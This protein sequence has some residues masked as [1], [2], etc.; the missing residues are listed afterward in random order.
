[1]VITI[2]YEYLP[3][4]VQF[5]LILQAVVVWVQRSIYAR[6][7]KQRTFKWRYWSQLEY[8]G[9]DKNQFS[10]SCSR[11]EGSSLRRFLGGGAGQP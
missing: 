7:G 6:K 1:M 4:V 11:A 10:H 3:H 8:E 2:R 9:N 5:S